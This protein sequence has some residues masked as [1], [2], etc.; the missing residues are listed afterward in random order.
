MNKFFRYLLIAIIFGLIGWLGR[1]FFEQKVSLKNP[2][3]IIK[4][5]IL[6]KYA[7][8]NLA[9]AE[10]KPG[11]IKIER[12]LKQEKS[13]TSSL[14]SLS[15][16]PDL[17]GKETKKTTGLI[18][19]PVGQGPFPLVVMVRGYV[20]QKQYQTGDGTKRAGEYFAKNGFMTI[21]PDFLGYGESDKESGDIFES[22]FQT[23]TTILSLLASLNQLEE[24]DKTNIFLW[25]HS[26]GGQVAL[27]ILEIS[28]KD[29]PVVLWAPVS[30]GFPQSI[31]AYIEGAQD[32]GKLLIQKLSEFYDLYD[33]KL[34][35]ISNYWDKINPETKL[36]I[37]QG[38]ADDAIPVYWTNTLVKN[39][40]NQDLSV[41]YFTYPGADH[42]LQPS[43]NT[44]IVR[45]LRFFEKNRKIKKE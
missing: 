38:T 8:E 4:P 36:Q 34:Y 9:Q 12:I 41:N 2:A 45:D 32:N 23:Y 15:F 37:H 14:F 26:N 35:S 31:L 5:R 7:F 39:L 18:N 30:K 6:D 19:I 3:S 21:A 44:V 43:W 27:T 16:R 29:Y 22:R 1:D 42:N 10:I 28:Q 17:T 20:D 25:G 24:W 11:E 40:K 33:P 13:F